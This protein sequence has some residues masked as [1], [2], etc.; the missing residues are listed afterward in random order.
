M[1]RLTQQPGAV[2]C[3][4]APSRPLCVVAPSRP[5]S[6]LHADDQLLLLLHSPWC[7]V[8]C[9]VFMVLNAGSRTVSRG[10]ACYYP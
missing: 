6:V 9:E 1:D 4:V 10:G 7:G 3:V 5:L 8:P 2:Q